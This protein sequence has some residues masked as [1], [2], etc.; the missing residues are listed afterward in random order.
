[1]V[2]MTDFVFADWIEKD[3]ASEIANEMRP[4]VKQWKVTT[5]LVQM[6]EFP[7]RD[8]AA[9]SDVLMSMRLTFAAQTMKSLVDI[10]PSI[11]GGVP[12]LTGTRF[13]VARVIAELADGT[14][15]SKLARNFDLNKDNIVE[16]LHSIAI[17]LDRPFR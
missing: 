3:D 2:T 17:K 5:S 4:S 8:Y 16:V 13:T 9:S 6:Y 11:A 7:D 1:M 10:D 12:V 15:V 14:T